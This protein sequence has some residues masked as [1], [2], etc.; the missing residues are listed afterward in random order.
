MHPI[1]P[2][3]SDELD[4][5]LQKALSPIGINVQEASRSTLRTRASFKQWVAADSPEKDSA[6]AANFHT[7]VL[8]V[9]KQGRASPELCKHLITDHLHIQITSLSHLGLLR[10]RETSSNL[11][12]RFHLFVFPWTSFSGQEKGSKCPRAFHVAWESR[13]PTPTG[14]QSNWGLNCLWK[15]LLLN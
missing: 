12:S 1:H 2:W 7:A 10:S 4:L 11:Y 8:S 14:Q 3:L 13:D 6:E 5:A 15:S 9:C